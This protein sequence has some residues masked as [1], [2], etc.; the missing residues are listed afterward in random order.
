MAA[1]DLTTLSDVKAWLNVQTTNDDA[2]LTRLI[3]AASTFI[4]SWLNR[5]IA[6]QSYTQTLNGN[7]SRKMVLENWPI[8]A[9]SSLTIDGVVVSQSPNSQ[10][11]G[12]MFDDKVVY[13]ISRSFCRGLQNIVI[14]YTAG[15][16]SVPLDIA[17][18]C[19]ELVSMRYRERDRIGLASKAVGGETTAYSLK[20]MSDSVRAQLSQ[21]RRVVPV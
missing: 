21:Y 2:L 9:V 6:S 3:S 4:Q 15:Y 12:Y 20:D 8:T 13:L 18:A 1:G 17:Q 10:T 7:A 11:T 14:S 19:I 16:S 5:Q